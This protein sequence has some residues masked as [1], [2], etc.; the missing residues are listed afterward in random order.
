DSLAIY[1]FQDST[2]S[3]SQKNRKADAEMLAMP[4][5]FVA[6]SGKLSCQLQL[7][8]PLKT[9]KLASSRPGRMVDE[10]SPPP[11]LLA[12]FHSR[13]GILA[14]S[15]SPIGNWHELCK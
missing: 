12:D 4:A 8:R 11:G 15:A 3:N 14:A 7:R 2:P 6:T 1:K 13:D 9:R 10:R 5:E